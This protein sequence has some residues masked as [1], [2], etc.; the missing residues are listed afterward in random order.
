MRP[1]QAEPLEGKLSDGETAN[2]ER[3]SGADPLE[4]AER[5]AP[6]VEA[7][8]AESEARRELSPAVFETL[9]D[10]GFY[11][12]LLPLSVGGRELPPSLFS[13]VLERIARADGSTAWCLGQSGGCAM[14]GGH[15]APEVAQEIFGPPR[16]V[17][18]WGAGPMGRAVAV[19]GGYRVTGSWPFASGG[20]QANWL[21]AHVPLCD[22]DGTPLEEEGQPL[23]RTMLFP[24]ENA[25]LTDNWHVVGLRATGSD[26]Y[27]V[28]GLFVPHERS[29]D[30]EGEP[31]PSQSGVLYRFPITLV[32]AAGFAGVA[33]GL[34]RAMLDALIDLAISKVPQKKKATLRDSAVVQM[35]VAQ[36]EA[37]LRSA[38][39]YLWR[40]L[41]EIEEQAASSDSRRITTEQR[42]RL[43]LAATYGIHQAAEVA[44]IAY[45]AAGSTAIFEN[46]KFERRFRDIHAVTQQIQAR[47]SQYET[48]GQYLL[49]V[50]DN[51]ANY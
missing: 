19:D 24:A 21:G 28:E 11:R 14:A 38:T 31:D 33:F 27:A 37:K 39:T 5:I 46:G 7:G 25:T 47:Q 34:A 26:D 3:F 10:A 35:Q 29:F 32:Y 13:Q 43:R 42:M 36:A 40:T 18:A 51:P 16:A 17:L 20:R 2:R 44:D 23:V 50:T 30:M 22:P 49:G 15:L 6:Q 41:E 4:L 9:L 48:V 8:A 12:L 1:A 45:L